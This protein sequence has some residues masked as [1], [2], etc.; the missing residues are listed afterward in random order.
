MKKLLLLFI[1]IYVNLT[2]TFAQKFAYVDTDYI[3]NKIPEFKQAQ[4]KLDNFSADWQAEI[5]SKYV[6]VEKMYRAYQQEKVLLTENMKSKREEAIITKET[7]AKNLQQKYF[8]PEGQ[9]FT[10]RQEL[11]TPIQDKIQNA[12][13]ELAKANKYQ[14][15][16][17]SSSDLIMLH[18]DNNLDQSDKVLDLMGY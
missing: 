15:V 1:F 7:A 17:D 9:L 3:L 11:I 12:I 16:F 18:K 13:K 8:G 5:E 2:T 4:D 6:A 10:K 14:I